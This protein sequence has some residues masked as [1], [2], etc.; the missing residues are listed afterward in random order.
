[1]GGA[2]HRRPWR[3]VLSKPHARCTGDF[4]RAKEAKPP[5]LHATNAQIDAICL[6]AGAARLSSRRTDAE[7]TKV[8]YMIDR[9]MSIHRFARPAA[10]G[11]TDGP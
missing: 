6:A 1:M 2:L 5:N 10:T 4:S 11:R 3:M 7:R 8:S 9:E